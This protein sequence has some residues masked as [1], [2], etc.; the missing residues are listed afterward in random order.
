MTVMEYVKTRDE[1]LYG[2]RL[3]V[4]D[5]D[6]KK[7]VGHWAGFTK[8]SVDHVKVTTKHIFIYA[9]EN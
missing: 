6:T 8:W 1:R 2:K 3:L 7:Y 4:I 9:R 5:A